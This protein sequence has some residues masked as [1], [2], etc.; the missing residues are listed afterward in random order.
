MSIALSPPSIDLLFME[1]ACRS[2]IYSNLA[3]F[4][5][6][7]NPYAGSELLFAEWDRDRLRRLKAWAFDLGWREAQRLDQAHRRKL[8]G[9]A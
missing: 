4:H 5:Q 7:S 9:A 8:K 1:L 2:G 6:Q 3:G